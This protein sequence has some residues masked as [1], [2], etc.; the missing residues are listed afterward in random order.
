MQVHGYGK[1]ARK[2]RLLK[3]KF[4]GESKIDGK[5][6]EGTLMIEGLE[7]CIATPNGRTSV[8]PD[9]V[10]EVA[11]GAEDLKM[12]YPKKRDLDGIYFRV[13]R[14]GK[15]QNV[16]MT[17]LSKDEFDSL[18]EG[19]HFE[20]LWGAFDYLTDVSKKMFDSAYDTNDTDEAREMLWDLICLIRKEADR[21]GII[22]LDDDDDE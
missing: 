8:W 2:L 17:D 5:I 14:D 1:G 12:E 18:A 11:E 3:M 7:T 4:K 10:E 22:C 6:I 9:S 21:M 20:W 13:C 16:C 15:W 19:R